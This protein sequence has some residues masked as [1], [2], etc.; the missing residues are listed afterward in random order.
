MTDD[1][2]K[3][4]RSFLQAQRK[5]FLYD[6]V[7][8]LECQV[9][10]LKGYILRSLV[11]YISEGGIDEFNLCEHGKLRSHHMVKTQFDKDV[12]RMAVEDLGKNHQ[13][14]VIT[15]PLHEVEIDDDLTGKK[16]KAI[17]V[18]IIIDSSNWM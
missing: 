16:E 11:K 4:D 5:K 18:Q 6:H 7:G 17:P 14:R 8:S 1:V 13:I 2:S 12:L 9:N 3:I 10:Q 15:L